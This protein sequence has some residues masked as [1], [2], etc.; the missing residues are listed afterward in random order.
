V[1]RDEIDILEA[2]QEVGYRSLRMAMISS[3]E[4][5][6]TLGYMTKRKEGGKWN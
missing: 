4:A 3:T 5:V 1:D 2:I 6:N